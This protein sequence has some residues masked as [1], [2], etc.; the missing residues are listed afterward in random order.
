[1]REVPHIDRAFE[2]TR[3]SLDLLSAVLTTLTVHRTRMHDAASGSWATATGLAD[4]IVH[5]S[6]LS[7]RQAHSIVACVVRDAL[8]QGIPPM[9]VTGD[10]LALAC[11]NAGMPP[12]HLDTSL[13]RQALD[14]TRF[15]ET[16]TSDG[17]AGGAQIARMLSAAAETQAR[18]E[19]SANGRRQAVAGA[20]DAL[21]RICRSLAE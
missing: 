16:R 21:T 11:R 14:A 18:L 8:E 13:I 20:Q 19:A 15:V 1:M 3:G 17:G 7:F 4:A 5:A 2:A 12:L 10:M 9:S 6:D